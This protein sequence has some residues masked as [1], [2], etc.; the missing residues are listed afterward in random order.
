M[1]GTIRS[2]FRLNSAA[3]SAPGFTL[4]E[5]LA[6]MAVLSVLILVMSQ[7]VNVGS[8]AWEQGMRQSERSTSAR[9]ALDFIAAELSTAIANDRV[10]FAHFDQDQ[11]TYYYQDPENFSDQLMFVSVSRSPGQALPAR[12]GAEVAYF[13]RQM[14]DSGNKFIDRYEL[15]RTYLTSEATGYRAYKQGEDW[16]DSDPSAA[17]NSIIEN[18]SAFQVWVYPNIGSNAELNYHSDSNSDRLPVWADIYI[19]TLSETD[20]KLAD[21][22]A[23]PGVRLKFVQKW[24]R[25][26]ATRVHFKNRSGYNREM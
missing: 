14:K 17:G 2:D 11:K 24:S 1:D 12:A 19:E 4:I 10:A 26:Y 18:V 16:T 9:A 15:V 25:G 23:D 7:F 5:L 22:I 20:A 3:V 8:D 21:L 13:V 6:G